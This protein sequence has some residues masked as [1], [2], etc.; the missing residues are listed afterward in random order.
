MFLPYV[1]IVRNRTNG[2]FYIGMRSANKVVAEQ[3]LG[4][5]YFTSSK[6][7][8]NNF[9]EFDTE[10]VAYFVDQI[11]AF[12]FENDLIKEHWGDSLLLNR[13]YQKSMSKFSMAGAKRADLAEYN[14]KTK[15]KPKEVRNYNCTHC[16]DNLIREEFV[17]LLP[18]EHY[19]CNATCRN[20]F[21]ATQRK[22]M[23]GISKPYKPGRIAWNKGLPNQRSA[24]NGKK[25]ASK[26]SS[27]VIGR[28]KKVL[29]DG[30]WTWEYPNKQ[31]PKLL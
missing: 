30:T 16:N 29:A 24:I 22:S 6:H 2:K 7:V 1:Y 31:E 14:R 27:T 13:H 3:D 17:H 26:Q 8:K 21:I 5:H 10:I 11:S 15:S 9:A 18:K 4:T 12:E 20:K 19:Y 25:S 28:K 23:R